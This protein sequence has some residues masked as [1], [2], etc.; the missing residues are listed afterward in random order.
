MTPRRLTD[1]I[2]SE[3]HLPFCCLLLFFLPLLPLFFLFLQTSGRVFIGWPHGVICCQTCS[4]CHP[5][6]RPSLSRSSHSCFAFLIYCHFISFQVFILCH[7]CAF[8]FKA[9]VLHTHRMP[10][11]AGIHQCSKLEHAAPPH[12]HTHTPTHCTHTCTL[13]GSI[14]IK[15]FY[16]LLGTFMH[17]FHLHARHNKRGKKSRKDRKQSYCLLQ[18]LMKYRNPSCGDR[19]RKERRGSPVVASC[20]GIRSEEGR[21]GGKMME[22]TSWRRKEDNQCCNNEDPPPPQPPPEIK[23]C[24]A[25]R[26][27][28]RDGA[29]SS[30]PAR[31]PAA[32]AL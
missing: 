25:C 22:K 6:V 17:L 32:A 1:S 14:N 21:A 27:A 29:L 10:C 30:L 9:E 7:C 20:R 15:L 26:R 13:F 3:P 11:E 16:P 4:V 2:L 12:T 19:S 28:L 18:S 31:L 5:C 23:R 8:S 24:P